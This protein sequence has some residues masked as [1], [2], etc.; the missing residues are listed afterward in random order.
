VKGYKDK[1][2]LAGSIAD[3]QE[4]VDEMAA[5][6]DSPDLK[7]QESFRQESYDFAYHHAEW[8]KELAELRNSVPRLKELNDSLQRRVQQLIEDNQK[9]RDKKAAL[10]D[11]IADLA[12]DLKA[13]E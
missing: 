6:Q 9:L 11:V 4:Q 2:L 13:R 12:M 8:L 10:A 7:V 5:R 3:W 1:V